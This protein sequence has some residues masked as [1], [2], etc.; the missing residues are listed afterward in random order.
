MRVQWR[1]KQLRLS[2]AARLGRDVTQ[3]EVSQAT[4]ISTSR[5]SV[6]ENGKVRGVEFD[7]LEKL[8]RF[9]QVR[10]VGE[11]LQLITGDET[12][13]SAGDAPAAEHDGGNQAPARI[14]A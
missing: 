6:I 3:E 14:A 12:H 4:G 2:L 11:L 13:A 1:A 10:D 5:L 7:T 9:Y 8:A